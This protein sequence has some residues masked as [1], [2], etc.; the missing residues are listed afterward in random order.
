ME[1]MKSKAIFCSMFSPFRFLV[2]P[3]VKVVMISAA[4]ILVD[5]VIEL[6]KGIAIGSM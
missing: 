1:S 6:I 3:E 4:F 2:E 5:L